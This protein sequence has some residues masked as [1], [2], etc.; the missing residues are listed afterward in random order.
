MI[1]TVIKEPKVVL[2]YIQDLCHKYKRHRM[3]RYRKK[4]YE[5]EYKDMLTTKLSNNVHY[6]LVIPV[7]AVTKVLEDHFG[8]NGYMALRIHCIDVDTQS[9]KV[10][11][12]IKLCRP[13]YLIGRGGKDIDAVTQKLSEVFSRKTII[14]IT[15]VKIDNNFPQDNW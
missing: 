1:K 14:N 13:G 15:E 3:D 8:I 2:Y 7:V 6:G 12:G 11:V 9:D 4:I 10:T 5:H